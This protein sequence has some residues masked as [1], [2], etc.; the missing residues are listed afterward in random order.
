MR[1]LLMQNRSEFLGL[2]SGPGG[3]RGVGADSH[4]GERMQ[5]PR[6]SGRAELIASMLIAAMLLLWMM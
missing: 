1:A 4:A 5:R 3:A 2:Q 6:Q